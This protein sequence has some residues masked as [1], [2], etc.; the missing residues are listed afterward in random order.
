MDA[1]TEMRHFYDVLVRC[2]LSP[3]PFEEWHAFYS[4]NTALW[5][6]IA[7]DTGEMIG[8]VLFKGHLIHMAVVP[9]WQGRWLNKT[10][11]RAYRTWTNEADV[12]A[13]I[14]PDNTQAITLAQRLGWKHRGVEEGFE[15][16][17]K[18]KATCP[19]P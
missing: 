11:L 13:A 4:V 16:Y 1:M 14:P 15:I 19:Q 17:V 12:I 5:P 3:P 2:K 7:R 8:G 6:I 9:E 18:E 10:V